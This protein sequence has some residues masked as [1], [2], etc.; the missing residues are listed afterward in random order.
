MNEDNPLVLVIDDELPLQ[1]LMKNFLSSI[2]N[3]VTK[4]DGKSALDWIQIGNIPDLIVCDVNMEPMNGEDFVKNLRAGE[5]YKHI[6]LVML[7]GEEE[8]K[9]RIKFYELGVKYFITKPFNPEEL[10]VLS[11]VILKEI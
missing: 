5:L 9:T 2:Y 1:L 7:S 4:N 11:K 3:V 10:L 6:P 8:S